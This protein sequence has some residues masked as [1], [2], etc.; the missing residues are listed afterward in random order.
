MSYKMVTCFDRQ[1]PGVKNNSTNRVVGYTTI[2]LKRTMRMVHVLWFF[3]AFVYR[4][5]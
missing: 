4:N 1:T 3:H 5:G 2:T